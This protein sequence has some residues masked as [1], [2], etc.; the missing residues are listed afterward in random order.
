[1]FRYANRADLVKQRFSRKIAEVHHLDSAPL[2]QSFLSDFFSRRIPLCAALKVMRLRPLHSIRLRA[3]PIRPT[4]HQYR[5][6]PIAGLD[7]KLA[8]DMIELVDLRRGQ[9]VGSFL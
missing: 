1:V 4:P 2:T 7:P 8:A 3:S 6:Q 5:G 9:I